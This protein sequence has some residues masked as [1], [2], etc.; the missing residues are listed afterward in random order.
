MRDFEESNYKLNLLGS[1]NRANCTRKYT[2]QGL[3]NEYYDLLMSATDK[4]LSMCGRFI[5]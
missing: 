2:I 3:S 1:L 5:I 4:Y